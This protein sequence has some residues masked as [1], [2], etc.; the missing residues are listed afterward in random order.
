M[1]FMVSRRGFTLV[2]LL[3]VIAVIGVLIATLLPA[4][5]RAREASR[6]V[7]CKNNLKQIG[8]AVVNYESAKKHYPP[9]G[10]AGVGTNPNINDG[11]FSPRS[12]NMISWLVLVLPYMEENS[13]YQQFDL[14]RSILN[15]PGDPQSNFVPTL[16]CP[17]DEA[18]GRFLKD[19]GMTSNKSLAKGNYAAFI[20][21]FHIDQADAYPGGLGGNRP[22]KRKNNPEGTSKQLLGAEVRTRAHIQDQRGAWTLPWAGSSVLSFDIHPVSFQ[23]TGGV[24]QGATYSLGTSQRPNTTNCDILYATPDPTGAQLERMYCALYST[25]PSNNGHYISAAPRSNHGGGANA[26]LLDGRITYLTDEIDE[27]VMAYLISPEDFRYVDMG[28]WAP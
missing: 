20:S 12:G 13:L 19:A 2:E 18:K 4:V 16:I 9:G 27:F 24:Y 21:P 26:V 11:S 6:R 5:Q 1:L 14:R 17:T 23:K 15:Q 8:L 22:R 25:S 3:V 7:S 10:I 28:K